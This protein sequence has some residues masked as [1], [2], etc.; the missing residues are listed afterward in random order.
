MTAREISD[1]QVFLNACKT[2]DVLPTVRQA[3]KCRAGV[4]RWKDHPMT[5]CINNVNSK[6][7]A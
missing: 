6:V 4:G 5:G 7:A 2:M 3:R 1:L